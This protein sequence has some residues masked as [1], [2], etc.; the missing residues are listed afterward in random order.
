VVEVGPV[1][2]EVDP[3]VVE[4]GPVVVEVGPVVVEVVVVA[5]ACANSERMSLCA[6]AVTMPVPQSWNAT[7]S[8]I[9]RPMVIRAR[10]TAAIPRRMGAEDTD[11]RGLLHDA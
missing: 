4:V 10:P 3:V 1:V 8:R 11:A 6:R 7:N 2:V 9:N 5:R